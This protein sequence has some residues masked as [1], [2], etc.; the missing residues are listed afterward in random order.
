VVKTIYDPA[1]GTGGMLSVAE[2]YIRTLNAEAQPHLFGQDWND[3]AYGICR[4][5][6]LIKGEDSDNIKPDSNFK[7]NET[8]ALGID[9]VLKQVV[10]SKIFDNA[11]FGYNK[12]TVERP[13]RLN[14]KASPERIIRLA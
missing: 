7:H 11:D 8:R 14:F 1:C 2:K 13:L 10:V 9:G 5:D 4:A 6:M 3:E 12:I